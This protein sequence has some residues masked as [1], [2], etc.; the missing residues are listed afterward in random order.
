MLILKFFR[1]NNAP[2]LLF[3]DF[4]K[5]K[6]VVHQFLCVGRLEENSIVECKHQHI[7]NVARALYFSLGC[8]SIFGENAF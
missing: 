2:E 6:G 1:S 5:T 7:L 4:F 3:T 8:L